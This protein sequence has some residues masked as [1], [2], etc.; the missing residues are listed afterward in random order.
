MAAHDLFQDVARDWWERYMLRGNRAY[1]EESWRR[2]QR[3]VMPALGN[4][5]VKSIKSPAILT[6]LRTIEHRGTLETAYKVKSHIN[7]I[8]RYAIACGLIYSNPARD[9]TWALMP[10]KSTPRAALTE[11]R[12]VGIFMHKIAQLPNLQRRYSLQLAALLFVRPGELV[13]AEWSEIERETNLWRIPG[14]KM[15][16]KRPHIVPLSHQAMETLQN[17]Q[18]LTGANRWLFPSRWNSKQHETTRVLTAAIRRMGYGGDT[19]TAHGCRAMAATIL[20]EQGWSSGAI[21]R[22]L[23]HVDKNAVRAAYQRSEL[24]AERRKMMQ[25]WADFLDMRCAWAILNK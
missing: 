5:Q 13:Q 15:K 14:H 19:M 2:L 17:L 7:Q 22:Q 1:A 25:A 24:L 9:L 12:Q 18:T 21:E 10:K 4:K 11:P 20:S 3:D 23:A 8:L 6:V 16:M